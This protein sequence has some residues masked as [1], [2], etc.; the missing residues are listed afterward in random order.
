ME[1]TLDPSAY[2]AH[3][4]LGGWLGGVGGGIG[5]FLLTYALC[6]QAVNLGGYGSLVC[7][8]L[9]AIGYGVGA[10]V[11][12]AVGVNVAGNLNHVQGNWFL[13]FLGGIAGGGVAAAA[14]GALDRAGLN[15][16]ALML[17]LLGLGVPLGSAFGAALGYNIDAKLAP[18]VEQ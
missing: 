5:G 13:S 15:H 3:E 11:G 12:A 17:P 4:V 9:G 16:P 1:V 6:L 2:F 18:P 8:G 14:V 7:V 10:P